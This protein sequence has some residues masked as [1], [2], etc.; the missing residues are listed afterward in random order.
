MTRPSD[1]EWITGD[2]YFFL[3]YNIMTQ[4][5]IKETS[6]GGTYGSR[7]ESLPES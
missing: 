4:T 5:V 2:F 1:G 3:N 7:I 6:T